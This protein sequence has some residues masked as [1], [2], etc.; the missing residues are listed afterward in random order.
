MSSSTE[1]QKLWYPT[2]M[3]LRYCIHIII[4][5]VLNTYQ[6]S[7]SLSLPPF[8]PSLLQLKPYVSYKTPYVVAKPITAE[9]I[10]SIV[11][12]LDSVIANEDTSAS[13]K[14]ST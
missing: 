14:A 13:S 10:L 1:Y 8:S 11:Q 2:W 4:G 6:L 3:D 7:F 9:D 5:N 12:P